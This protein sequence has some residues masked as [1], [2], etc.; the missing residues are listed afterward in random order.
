MFTLKTGYD[1][2]L[3]NI[4]FG[5]PKKDSVYGDAEELI[6]IKKKLYKSINKDKEE[7]FCVEGAGEIALSKSTGHGCGVAAGFGFGV[8][9]GQFGFTGGVIGLREAKRMAEFILQKI[10]EDPQSEEEKIA[11][12]E[13]YFNQVMKEYRENKCQ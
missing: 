13:K 2:S 10:A 4:I 5:S 6:E 7:F 8:S 9:W 1:M 11:D 3:F 12:R